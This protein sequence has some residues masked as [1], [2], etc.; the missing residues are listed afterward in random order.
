MNLWRKIK[1]NHWALMILTCILPLAAL[2]ILIPVFGMQSIWL[3]LIAI[4]IC[5]G[6]HIWMMRSVH[7]HGAKG[8]IR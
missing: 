7:K 5:L 6:S 8:S 3:A 4:V 2:V 1:D